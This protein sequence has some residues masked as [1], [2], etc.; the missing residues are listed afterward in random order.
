MA[1]TLILASC[2]YHFIRVHL[3]QHPSNDKSIICILH[4]V[5]RIFFWWGV[6][7]ISN[8]GGAPNFFFFV[9]SNIIPPH[10]CSKISFCESLSAHNLQWLWT[11]NSRCATQE[12]YLKKIALWI[13]NLCIYL[14]YIRK[15]GTMGCLLH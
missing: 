11:P 1:G 6:Y 4:Q 15:K 5:N 10:S 2:V 13:R 14:S 3:V 7:H 8:F 9:R 12:K